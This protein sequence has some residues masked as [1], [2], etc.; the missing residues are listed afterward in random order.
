MGASMAHIFPREDAKVV[1]ADVLEEEGRS[2]AAK[3]AADRYD[4]GDDHRFER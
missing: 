1:V 4:V 2:A 3:F